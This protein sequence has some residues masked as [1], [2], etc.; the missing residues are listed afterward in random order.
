MT[1]F[2]WENKELAELSSPA[3]NKER[4]YPQLHRRPGT[5]QMCQKVKICQILV[6]ILTL[7]DKIEL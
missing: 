6:T 4:I 1:D 2:D 3:L 5:L 7:L